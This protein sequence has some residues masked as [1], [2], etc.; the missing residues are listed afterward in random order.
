[1]GL[2]I[3]F[4]ERKLVKSHRHHR[5]KFCYLLITGHCLVLMLLDSSKRP[6]SK[7]HVFLTATPPPPH[8][9]TCPFNCISAANSIYKLK[10]WF[11]HQN[12]HPHMQST[13]LS[14]A[15]H[16]MELSSCDEKNWGGATC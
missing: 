6:K 2:A 3:S 10:I 5:N 1:M 9:H 4:P 7:L 13:G 14:S 11:Q 15:L 8:T 12:Q 16:C